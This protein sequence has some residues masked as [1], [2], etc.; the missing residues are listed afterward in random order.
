MNTKI[1]SLCLMLTK[2]RAENV[3]KTGTPRLWRRG[4]GGGLS[5]IILLKYQLGIPPSPKNGQ[6][7]IKNMQVHT[8][9]HDSMILVHALYIYAQKPVESESIYLGL[10]V[11]A[12]KYIV[13]NRSI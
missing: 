9:I 1:P 10:K 11:Y 4:K 7:K 13:Y 8:L 3:S 5:G 12:K 2:L 6:L